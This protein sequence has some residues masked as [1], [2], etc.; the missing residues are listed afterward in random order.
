[1][2]TRSRLRTVE[3]FIACLNSGDIDGLARVCDA[4]VQF[5]DSLSET[6]AGRDNIIGLMASF[7]DAALGLKVDPSSILTHRELVLVRA[8]MRSSDPRFA[9]PVYL[10]F[11]VAGGKIVSIQSS[12]GADAASIIRAYRQPPPRL[13]A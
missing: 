13:Q 12:R 8:E 1:M 7:G 5:I 10:T 6:V 3:T 2:L 11:L 4:N 9:G